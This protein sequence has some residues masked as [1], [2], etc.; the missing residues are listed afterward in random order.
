MTGLVSVASIAA[1][2]RLLSRVQ[3]VSTVQ[4]TSG[5][6][7]EFLF[8]VGHDEHVDLG[9]AVVK[10]QGFDAQIVTSGDGVINVTAIDPEAT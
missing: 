6:D 4:V 1:F 5:P 9:A 2:K 10:L 8:G 3:G 7:G